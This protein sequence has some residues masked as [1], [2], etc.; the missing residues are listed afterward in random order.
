MS[1]WKTWQTSFRRRS[2]M[3]AC[4]ALFLFSPS[5]AQILELQAADEVA[6]PGGLALIFLELTEPEPIS[7]GEMR[8]TY[9]RRA[10]AS[11]LNVGFMSRSGDVQGSASVN[12]GEV[13]TTFSSPGATFGLDLDLPIMVIA[14]PVRSS[15]IPGTRGPLKIDRP[16]SEFRNPSGTPYPV[17]LK[18]GLFTVGGV[19]VTRMFPSKGIVSAGS[20][21]TLRGV[22][23]QQGLRINIEEAI[24]GPEQFI[25]SQWAQVT[26]L[27]DFEIQDFTRVRVRNPDG[28]EDF[29]YPVVQNP[30]PAS[31][32]LT[33]QAPATLAGDSDRLFLPQFVSGLGLSTEIRL[34]NRSDWSAGPVFWLF[35]EQGRLVDRV[36][37][38]PA[39][40]N[41]EAGARLVVNGT[42]LFDSRAQAS[43]TGSL[44]I[45][46]PAGTEATAL[47]KGRGLGTPVPILSTPFLEALFPRVSKGREGGVDLFSGLALQN[48][49]SE[50]ADL[51]VEVYSG[52]GEPIGSASFSLAPRGRVA[53]LLS[54]LVGELGSQRGGHIRVTS[55][56]AIVGTEFFGNPSLDFM[57]AVAGEVVR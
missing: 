25:S 45:E 20:K 10:L 54:D 52:G 34:V 2:W 11:P 41:L 17:I 14:I 31:P 28:S 32:P 57:T 7:G 24:T 43:L 4:V 22:G 12:P 8:F 53:R 36:E 55:S 18:N 3:S 51:L 37:V 26:L 5:I 38:D 40:R 13:V 1:R 56:Q 19:S 47:I 44:I 39:I 23:F 27:A 29:Y 49:T 46:V 50:P 6:P 30:P 16:S 21:I 9:G 48:T 33:G 35:D 15:A 42:D